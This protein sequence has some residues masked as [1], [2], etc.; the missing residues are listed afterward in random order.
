MI[1]WI[2]FTIPTLFADQVADKVFDKAIADAD[3]I[4]KLLSPQ[5][6]L[7]TLIDCHRDRITKI[8]SEYNGNPTEKSSL[9]KNLKETDR[10]TTVLKS[11]YKEALGYR[12]KI[13]DT[14]TEYL[15]IV[16]SGDSDS[17]DTCLNKLYE[18][19]NKMSALV[20]LVA[21]GVASK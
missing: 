10:K 11:C 3:L 4:V 15:I 1:A 5:G 8:F 18:L 17:A 13:V 14:K 9:E 7:Q 16:G 6:E 19:H 20:D 12:Q 2:G 21:D